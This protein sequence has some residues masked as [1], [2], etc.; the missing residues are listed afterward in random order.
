MSRIRSVAATLATLVLLGGVAAGCADEPQA[1]P[2][3]AGQQPTQQSTLGKPTVEQPAG[4]GADAYCDEMVKNRKA[5]EQFGTGGGELTAAQKAALKQEIQRLADI[6]PADVKPHVQVFAAGWSR[7]LDGK[8]GEQDAA[9]IQKM[10]T[11]IQSFNAWV[12]THCAGRG[13]T[14]DGPGGR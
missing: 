3:P 13:I 10:V 11:A 4:G 5:F 8:L 6:A 12:K 7:L 9:D 14:I 1:A 2:A